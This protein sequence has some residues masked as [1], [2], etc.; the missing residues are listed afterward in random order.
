MNTPKFKKVVGER[1]VAGIVDSIIISIV[2]SIP[3]LFFMFKDGFNSFFESYMNSVMNNGDMSELYS[4]E[5]FLIS[6]LSTL[7]ISY[8]YFAYMPYKMNGQTLGKKMMSIK[9]IDEFGNN[10]SLKQHSIRAVQVWSAYTTA[11]LLP[12][13]GAGVITYSVVSSTVSSIVGLLAFVSYV[14][15]LAKDDG[16]GLHDNMAGT[17]VVKTN[18]DFEQEFVEK[19]TKMG[20]WADVSYDNNYDNDSKEKSDDWYE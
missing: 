12:V 1:L 17:Y 3:S 6:V 15:I 10:P 4:V 8:L 20:D 13:L 16:R 19:T 2:S 14:M 9:A 11:L 5:F 7:V 18:V